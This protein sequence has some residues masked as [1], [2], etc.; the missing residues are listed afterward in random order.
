VGPA[1]QLPLARD[2][3]LLGRMLLLVDEMDRPAA[4]GPKGA[5]SAV[6]KLDARFQVRGMADVKTVV[7][8]AEDVDEEWS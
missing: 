6:V 3:L 5:A 2:G 4:G 1:L 7:G 8:A